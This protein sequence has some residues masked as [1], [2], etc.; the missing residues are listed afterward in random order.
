ME[1]VGALPDDQHRLHSAIAGVTNGKDLF[2]ALRREFPAHANIHE[3]RDW[4]A[5][6]MQYAWDHPERDGHKRRI[7]EMA[8]NALRAASYNYQTTLTECVVDPTTGRTVR[9]PDT[10]RR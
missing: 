7:V 4:G 3:G 9:K 6:L 8:E 5:R 2:P 10:R 1:E